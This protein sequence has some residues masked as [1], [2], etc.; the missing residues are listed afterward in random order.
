MNVDLAELK[1]LAC[2]AQHLSFRQAAD[3]LGLS[4]S[5]VSHAVRAMEAKVG[6]RLFNR[7]T[8][9][10][11]LTPA[12][13]KLLGRIAPA[14]QEIAEALDGINAYRDTPRGLLRLNAPRPAGELVLAPLVT[15]FLRQHPDVTV[16]LVLDDG[17]VDIVQAGFDAGVRY[18]E[19]LQQDMVAIPIGPRQRFVVVASPE[20]VQRHGRPDSPLALASLPCVGLRFP[21]GVRYRWE[22]AKGGEALQVE[23][24]GPLVL[25]DARLMVMA[26]Q[27]GLGFAYVY[28]QYA[29]SGLQ[30]GSLVQVLE[31]WS[32]DDPGFFLYYP[33][34][35]LVPAPLR[36]FIAMVQA[37][38]AR[39]HLSL[40]SA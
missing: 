34:R 19:S 21:S 13:Q 3:E 31:D 40:A 6:V 30:D 1:L 26:A 15:Q 27:Q 14:L 9:S 35:R 20:F 4:A 39:G 7:T 29:H 37:Q 23:V 8:R 17:L 36:A 22:F 12:G 38:P 10:V 16:D 28:A 33:S 18:G 24:D 32:P 5:A 25:G 2:I 11:A